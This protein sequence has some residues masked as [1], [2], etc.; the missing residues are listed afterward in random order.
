M[1]MFDSVWFSCPR[2]DEQIEVQS[3][4]GECVLSSINPNQ[5]PVEIAKDIENEAVYCEKCHR[6]WTVVALS[7]VRTV[8]MR[9][10]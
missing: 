10:A 7:F 3:K 5:V 9:L 6:S 1:G 4:A 8:P 2:C